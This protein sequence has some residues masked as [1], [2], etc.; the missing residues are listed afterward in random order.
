MEKIITTASI[1]AKD[2]LFG[3]YK[4]QYGAKTRDDFY[5]F[6]TTPS[7]ERELFL[8]MHTIKEMIDTGEVIIIN[9]K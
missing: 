4:N 9:A 2:R 7:P 8:E 5:T 3:I 1:E 6:L